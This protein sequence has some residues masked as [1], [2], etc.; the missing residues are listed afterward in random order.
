MKVT[1]AKFCIE[2][3]CEQVVHVNDSQ[4]SCGGSQFIFLGPIVNPHLM[5]ELREL[6]REAAKKAVVH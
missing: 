5:A 3:S 4:C 1:E 2:P 6:L